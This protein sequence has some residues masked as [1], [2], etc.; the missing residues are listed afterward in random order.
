M[1][2]SP[3]Q[4]ST[5]SR[6][7]SSSAAVNRL[8]LKLVAQ[9]GGAIAGLL[10]PTTLDNWRELVQQK[11]ASYDSPAPV[12]AEPIAPRHDGPLAKLLKKLEDRADEE[13]PH[14]FETPTPVV[15]A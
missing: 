13:E 6:I 2:L 8:P 14:P 11:N 5:T 15:G 9:V 4:L 10:R 3:A 12:S 7:S 1:R